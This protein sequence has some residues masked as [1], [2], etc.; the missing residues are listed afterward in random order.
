MMSR[1]YFGKHTLAQVFIGATQ[2]LVFFCIGLLFEDRLIPFFRRLLNHERKAFL[3]MNAFFGAVLLANVVSWIFFFDPQIAAFKD[4]SSIRC[5]HCFDD[6]LIKIRQSSVVG[7]QFAGLGYGFFLGVY[8]LNPRYFR[9]NHH[10]LHDHLSWKGVQR[11]LLMLACHLPLVLLIYIR[12]SPYTTTVSLFG[13][14]AVY[15]LSGLCIT[16]GFY[17]LAAYFDLLIEGDISIQ[18]ANDFVSDQSV[19]MPEK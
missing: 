17:K 6:K 15:V 4:Y 2:G 18:A 16:Y 5:S 13:S 19:D 12:D 14:M 8:F 7:F 1:V 9:Q 3:F 10:T 11:V